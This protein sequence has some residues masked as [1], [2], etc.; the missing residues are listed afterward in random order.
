VSSDGFEL[1]LEHAGRLLLLLSAAVL[2]W[3]GARALQRIWRPL[4]RRLR[5]LLGGIGYATAGAVCLVATVMT[6]CWYPGG[7]G[8]GARPRIAKRRASTV[9]EAI[10]Q[11]QIQ[12]GRL[13]DSLAE[14]GPA[15]IPDTILPEFQRWVGYPLEYK[16]DAGRVTYTLRFSYVGPGMNVCEWPPTG[17]GWHCFGYL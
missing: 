10:T 6:V 17:P 4:G 2:P 1:S 5:L 14:L 8:S 9:A 12:R 7:P 15:F 11:F 3:L 13:P 16:P